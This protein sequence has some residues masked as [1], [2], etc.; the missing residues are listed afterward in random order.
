MGLNKPEQLGLSYVDLYLVHH[1]RLAGG[2][3]PGLW[4]KMQ[5]IQ[6]DG[7]AK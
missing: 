1:P 4:A 3:I 7:K 6:A 5:K 2:D